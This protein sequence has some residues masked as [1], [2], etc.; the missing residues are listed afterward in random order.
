[1]MPE[2]EPSAPAPEG[3]CGRESAEAGKLATP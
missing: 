1:M 3:R 2:S